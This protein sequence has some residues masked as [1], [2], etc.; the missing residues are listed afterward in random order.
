MT[1]LNTQPISQ[2]VLAEKYLAAGEQTA[3]DL[4][5]RVSQALAD[6]EKPELRAQWAEKFF[7]NMQAGAI[8]AG[9]I[10]AAAGLDTKATLINCF[11]Q[12]VAD[13]TNGFDENGN[14]GIYT[15]LS[16][17]AET[18]RRGGGVGYDFSNLRPKGAKVKG[19]NSYASGPC[20]FI[21]MCLTLR[22]PPWNRQVRA[23]APKWASCASTTPMYWTSLPPSAKKAAGTTSTC[24]WA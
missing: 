13:A 8:G 21:D 12:P 1:S 17:A 14:P 5:R 19:T 24:L 22:A 20:S 11:V 18:M 9:R 7:Q 15:A 16:Q 2:D 23:A 10:M 4:F 3:E 6:Q